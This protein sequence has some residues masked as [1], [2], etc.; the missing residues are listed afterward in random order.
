MTSAPL[1]AAFSCASSS[2][3]GFTS[4][5]VNALS[6]D[7]LLFQGDADHAV[8]AAQIQHFLTEQA[9]SVNGIQQR[10]RAEIDMFLTEDAV[11][12]QKM[13]GKTREN[14]KVIS[15]RVLVLNDDYQ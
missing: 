10:P 6:G 15:F 4:A 14:R 9:R 8:P 5:S 2:A 1:R 7:I 11:V 12:R 3:R 13:T